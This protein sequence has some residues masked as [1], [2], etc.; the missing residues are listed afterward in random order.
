M[1]TKIVQL[2]IVVPYGEPGEIFD[3]LV[4]TL[5]PAGFVDWC[6]TSVPLDYDT[7]D[8]YEEGEF[9]RQIS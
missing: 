1:K 8:D 4:E 9:L 3:H 6:Y 2:A 5:R 7:P